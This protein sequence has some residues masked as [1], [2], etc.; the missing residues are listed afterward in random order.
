M[1]TSCSDKPDVTEAR[2]DHFPWM[3]SALNPGRLVS[4]RNPR[5]V[6]PSPLP[7]SSSTLAQITATSAIEPDVIHIFSPFSTYSLPTFF[8]RVRMPPGF[9]PKSGSVNPKHPSFSPF[10]SAGNQVFCCSSLP[11]AYMGYITSADC[12]LTNE[13]TPESPRSSSCV[14]SPYSTFDMPAQP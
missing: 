14:T 12:T 6:S 10:C 5:I 13:R 4:T 11:K 7:P 9:D 3:S 1:C 2:S 8:A